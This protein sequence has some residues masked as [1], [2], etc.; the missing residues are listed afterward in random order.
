MT[1]R[2]DISNIRIKIHQIFSLARIWSKRPS[3]TGEYPSDI[4]QF[5]KLRALRKIFEGL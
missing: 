3:E 5:S 4:P 2:N 1:L